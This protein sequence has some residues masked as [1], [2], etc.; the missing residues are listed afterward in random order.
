MP[1]I[2]DHTKQTEKIVVLE[3]ISLG[4]DPASNTINLV[5]TCS[6]NIYI[7]LS[8]GELDKIMEYILRKVTNRH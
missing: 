5:L 3:Q 8:D 6:D 7:E 4:K 1:Y 2:A